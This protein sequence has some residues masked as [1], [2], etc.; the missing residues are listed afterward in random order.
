MYT[1]LEVRVVS[2]YQLDSVIVQ[3]HDYNVVYVKIDEIVIDNMWSS[4]DDYIGIAYI[5]NVI[6]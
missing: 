4:V 2:R 6:Q 5:I 3:I 1:S